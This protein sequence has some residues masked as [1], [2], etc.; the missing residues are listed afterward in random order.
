[1]AGAVLTI[2][3]ASPIIILSRIGGLAWL[4]PL[5][6]QVWLT[7]VVRAEVLPGGKPAEP[8]IEDAIRQGVLAVLPE[9]WPE[10]Q[11]PT[12]DE[13]EASC[14]RAAL[15]TPGKHLI[16]MDERLGRVIAQEHGIAVAGTAA[17]IGLAKQR[18]LIDSAAAVFERL[19]QTDFRIA[20]GLIA[21][22]LRGVGERE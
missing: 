8:A 11:L 15:N 20:P 4:N 21:G 17:L 18:G 19:L 9:D 2:A 16:L 13:G 10:P 1:M 6:G 7:E 22:V 5:F 12:L 14:I 3:D